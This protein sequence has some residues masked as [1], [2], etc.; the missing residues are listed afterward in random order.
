VAKPTSNLVPIQPADPG[1]WPETL[2]A[3]AKG[4]LEYWVSKC[5][6]D[7]Y[8]KRS[9]IE[10]SE[11]IPILPYIFIAERLIGAESDYRFQLVGT[12]IVNIEGECTGQRLSELFSD[13]ARYSSVWQQYDE[14][15]MGVAYVRHQT[16]GWKGKQ[17]IDY[18][19]IL[20]PLYGNGENVGY[21]I[22][23]AYA[24]LKP[25]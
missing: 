13:R 23:T 24:A 11:I 17:Y 25:S 3:P 6:A 18:E 14:C 1:S 7:K 22:G 4:L 20:L 10:P 9:D 5:D 16:L 15:C 12:E 2:S 19:A 8:P 21:L